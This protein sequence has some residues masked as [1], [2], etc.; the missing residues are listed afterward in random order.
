MKRST[1]GKLSINGREALTGY[2][3]IAPWLIG[4]GIF[5]AYPLL[6]TIYMSFNDVRITNLG[7]QMNWVGFE[8]MTHAFLKD[9][10]FPII[11]VEEIVRMLIAIPLIILF[12]LFVSVL[13]HVRFPGRSVFRAFFFL[14][15]IFSTG[16]VLNQL[17]FQ[18][19]GGLTIL[20]QYNIA[21]FILTNFPKALADPLIQ[22]LDML[23]IILWYS[24]VQVLMFLIGFQTIGSQVYEAAR[25]DGSTAW[26]TLW[27][28][29]LPGLAPFILLNTIFT[30]VDMSTFPFS[31]VMAYIVGS[32]NTA[33]FGY[34][35]AIA[36][37]YFILIFVLILLVLAVFRRAS[38]NRRRG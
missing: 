36:L 7:L 2:L 11:L 6:F 20:E 34:I 33:G 1:R 22:V 10:Q 37:I 28:I 23:V 25:I 30:I 16:T 31:G 38:R 13:L 8:N 17:F 5:V 21:G 15:V 3:F 18:G 26:M 32:M 35:S 4:L 27:K 29:T 12:A 24:G 19:A 14:P 9:N